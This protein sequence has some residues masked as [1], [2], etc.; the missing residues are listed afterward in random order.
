LQVEFPSVFEPPGKY[1]TLILPAF[2]EKTRI[3]V[4]LDDM[5]SYL[6]ERAQKDA[7]FTFE[8]PTFYMRCIGL[9]GLAL[10]LLLL[11]GSWL[12]V[13]SCLSNNTLMMCCE[14]N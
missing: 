13:L 10:S 3:R 12:K 1:I 7:S 8:V 5:L 4:T 2:N 6:Q 9:Q 11:Q 14:V